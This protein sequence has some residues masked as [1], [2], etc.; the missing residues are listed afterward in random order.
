MSQIQNTNPQSSDSIGITCLKWLQVVRQK[1]GNTDP[2]LAPNGADGWGL[3]FK[4]IL[5]VIIS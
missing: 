1:K 3:T 4:K 2:N 5:A